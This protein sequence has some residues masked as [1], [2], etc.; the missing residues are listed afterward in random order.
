MHLWLSTKKT[1]KHTDTNTH[2]VSLS[3]PLLNGNQSITKQDFTLYWSETKG[4]SFGHTKE[5]LLWRSCAAAWLRWNWWTPDEAE[6][7]SFS[8]QRWIVSL[9]LM[10]SRHTRARCFDQAHLLFFFAEGAGYLTD[11]CY[12]RFLCNHWSLWPRQNSHYVFRLKCDDPASMQTPSRDEMSQ[13][14]VR[15]LKA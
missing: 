3:L 15:N 5:F 12:G 8:A 11:D 6:H 13:T 7:I 10:V 1:H 2:F 4:W 14:P 9:S